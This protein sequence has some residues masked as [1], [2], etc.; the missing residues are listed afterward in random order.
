MIPRAKGKE[1]IKVFLPE[2]SPEKLEKE[3]EL[4]TSEG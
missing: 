4:D 1:L 3:S 2:E